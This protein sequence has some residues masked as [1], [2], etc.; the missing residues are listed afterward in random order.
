MH[1]WVFRYACEC[2]YVCMHA[3]QGTMKDH[4]T[5]VR[6]GDNAPLRGK[7]SAEH[8]CSRCMSMHARK[9]E[10]VGWGGE[11]GRPQLRESAGSSRCGHSTAV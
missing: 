6:S 10:V 5:R 1:V 9:R 2:M 4:S 8:A 11:R 3:S 7:F